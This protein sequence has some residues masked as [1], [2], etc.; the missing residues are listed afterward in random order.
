[1]RTPTFVMLAVFVG[2]V[3]PA[4]AQDVAK[5]DTYFGSFVGSAVTRNAGTYS[6]AVRDRDLDVSIAATAGGGF[7]LTSTFVA[8]RG[9]IRGGAKRATT[10]L[11]F[12]PGD[13]PNSWRATTSK[14]LA[15]GGPTILARLNAQGLHVYVAT[16]GK[17]GKL[18]TAVYSRK[19]FQ[20]GR[21]GLRYHRAVDS[22]TVRSV[23]G[24][25]SRQKK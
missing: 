1:M 19:I 18:N 12:V 8:R 3:V 16:F 17:D 13:R 15:Q 23:F 21:M 9:F 2:C 24:T 11:T 6:Y 20:A 7:K 25:L 5:I 10:S 4:A 22:R 14:P